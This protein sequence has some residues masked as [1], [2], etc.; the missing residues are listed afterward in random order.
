M[1]VRF[2]SRSLK[3][4]SAQSHRKSI[5][6]E[7]FLD[8]FVCL[9]IAL[10]F[11]IVINTERFHTS[12]CAGTDLMKWGGV[13]AYSKAISSFLS[14]NSSVVGWLYMK[15]TKDEFKSYKFVKN[16][17]YFRYGMALINFICFF[18]ILTSYSKSEPCGLLNIVSLAYLIT[19]SVVVFSLC[20][21]NGVQSR[22]EQK[23]DSLKSE[24]DDD[25]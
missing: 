9:A 25:D 3:E 15:I 20:I 19:F 14:F 8:F 10:P 5:S 12:S 7:S 6:T 1:I 4:S 22:L 13:V 21:F 16:I 23:Y 11:L 2:T 24:E 17:N 18:G